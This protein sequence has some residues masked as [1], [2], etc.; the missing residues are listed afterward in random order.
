MNLFLKLIKNVKRPINILDVG[1]EEQFWKILGLDDDKLS[2][3]ILNLGK[4]EVTGKNFKSVAGDARDMGAFPDKYFDVV[5]SN[6]VIEHLETY[7]N[8]NM[9]A[10]EVM[11]VGK[12]YF[13][14]TPNKYFPIEPHFIFPFFQFF[15]MKVKILLCTRFSLGH[16]GRLNKAEAIKTIKSIRMVGTRELSE[17][18]PG[19]K[20]YKEKFI[21]MNKSIIAF[22][23]T[24]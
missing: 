20:V 21:G 5:F 17:L 19:S 12:M 8:Q 23:R 1:G 10:Q 24:R 9:M 13:I 3:T 2:I 11:R 16:V 4:L 15:P 22:G 14:Q 18:F 6:S 7:E